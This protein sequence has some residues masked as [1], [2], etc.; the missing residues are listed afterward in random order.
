MSSEWVEITVDFLMLE[1][2]ILYMKKKKKFYMC[3]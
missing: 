3:L 1:T 2:G